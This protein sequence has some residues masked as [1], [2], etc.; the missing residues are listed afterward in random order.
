MEWR[1]PEWVPSSMSS[2]IQGLPPKKLSSIA[3]PCFRCWGRGGKPR[4]AE[5]RKKEVREQL[6]G[7]TFGPSPRG[8][9]RSRCL[10]GQSPLPRDRTLTGDADG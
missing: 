6:E 1:E 10:L 2:A 5:E 9:L 7:V 4:Q 3:E 8:G